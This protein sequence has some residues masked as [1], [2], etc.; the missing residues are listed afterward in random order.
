MK[1]ACILN[2]IFTEDN[3]TVFNPLKV[4]FIRVSY[5]PPTFI[6]RIVHAAQLYWKSKI[7]D[8]P[9]QNIVRPSF[10]CVPSLMHQQ[11]LPARSLPRFLPK[12]T[13]IYFKAQGKIHHLYS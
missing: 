10:L 11:L 9:S 5:T 7:H 4:S 8:Q 3:F 12:M 6:R 2:S 13:V 1:D